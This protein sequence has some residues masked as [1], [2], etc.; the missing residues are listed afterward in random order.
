MRG[1]WLGLA[2]VPYLAAAAADAWMHEHGRRVPRAE[3][4]VHAALALAMLLFLVAVFRSLT[5]LAFAALALFAV[6]VVLD[7]WRF[8][9]AISRR[10]KSL[11]VLAWIALA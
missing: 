5:A 1:T 10:E 4:A 6:L 3:Q 9:G 2:L 7:E 11:H 8:H